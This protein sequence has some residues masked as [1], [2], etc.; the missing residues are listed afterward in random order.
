MQYSSR[1]FCTVQCAWHIY[2]DSKSSL[3]LQNCI[4]RKGMQKKARL[5]LNKNRNI[6]VL[7]RRSK[8]CLKLIV[9]ALEI[10][11]VISRIFT[12]K[13]RNTVK[14]FLTLIKTKVECMFCKINRCWFTGHESAQIHA[15]YWSE[16]MRIMAWIYADSERLVWTN[17]CTMWYGMEADNPRA[18]NMV[19]MN[20][21]MKY[22]GMLTV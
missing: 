10:C 22:R 17:K 13:H 14:V 4:A 16:L 15:L 2:Q 12:L 9:D 6:F 3:Y 11:L 19:V 5:T 1:M 20:N 21:S 8:V 18:F 7:K